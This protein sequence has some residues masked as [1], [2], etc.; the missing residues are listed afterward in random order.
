MC[1]EGQ[2][3]PIF[4]AW[5]RWENM[6]LPSFYELCT[7]H[8]PLPPHHCAKSK[9]LKF[10]PSRP[11]EL[12]QVA[13]FL[14]VMAELWSQDSVMSKEGKDNPEINY[15]YC[16]SQ[17]EKPDTLVYVKENV[18]WHVLPSAQVPLSLTHVTACDRREL[19]SEIRTQPTETA[20]L[21]PCVKKFLCL[22]SSCRAST[23]HSRFILIFSCLADDCLNLHASAVKW[24]L[25]A[26]LV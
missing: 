10:G 2:R 7:S 9:E 24:V 19:A 18:R 21:R 8:L 17:N 20:D 13:S 15:Y 14:Q 25:E 26:V 4:E 22:I 12:I 16:V 1:L 3:I 6:L 5:E 23:P 11:K